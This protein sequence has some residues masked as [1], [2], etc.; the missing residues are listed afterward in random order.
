MGRKY[1]HFKLDDHGWTPWQ[2][3]LMKDYRMAC[4]DCGLVHELEFFAAKKVTESKDGSFTVE[5]QNR[6]WYRVSFRARRD[7]RATAQKRRKK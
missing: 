7:E 3:P 2:Y 1:K 4:C 6:R 5:R